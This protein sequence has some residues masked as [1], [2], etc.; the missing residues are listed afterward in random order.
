RYRLHAPSGIQEFANLEQAA[1]VAEREARALAEAHARDAG[2][3]EVRVEVA[4]NDTVTK[5]KDG[6]KVFIETEIVA[7]A[8]GRPRLGAAETQG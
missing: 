2:A 6:S 1:E 5:G 7:T 3:V 4:R 8:L